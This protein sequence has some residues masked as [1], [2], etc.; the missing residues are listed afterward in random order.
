LDRPLKAPRG[1]QQFTCTLEVANVQE[2]GHDTIGENVIRVATTSGQNL[3]SVSISREIGRHLTSALVRA[4]PTIGLDGKV[5]IT[6]D[7]E[8]QSANH[9][10]TISL[11]QLVADAVSPEMLKDE[12]QVAQLLSEFRTRLLKSLELVDQAIASLPKP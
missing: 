10:T 12:P 6:F 2:L 5:S 1:S 4:A 11:D 9:V 7:D 8:F 3:M